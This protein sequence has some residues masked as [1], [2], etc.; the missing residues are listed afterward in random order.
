VQGSSDTASN[1]YDIAYD[2][3][4]YNASI[5]STASSS[6]HYDSVK[7]RSIY[8]DDRVNEAQEISCFVEE[9]EE[10]ERGVRVSVA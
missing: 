10:G 3:N 7:I 5:L 9:G 6:L 8:Y 4:Y 2:P 1:T